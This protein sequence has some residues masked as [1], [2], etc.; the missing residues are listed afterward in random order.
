MP[1]TK[2]LLVSLLLGTG[3]YTHDAAISYA[4]SLDEKRTHE[5]IGELSTQN[6]QMDEAALVQDLRQALDSNQA[7]PVLSQLYGELSDPD[8]PSP[9]VCSSCH[10]GMVKP[11]QV[12]SNHPVGPVAPAVPT[13]T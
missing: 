6:A 1:T 13:K 12:P 8:F 9:G 7:T 2:M 11:A 3:L 10:P 4:N 5:L